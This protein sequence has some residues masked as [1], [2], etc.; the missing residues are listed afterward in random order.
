M[1]TERPISNALA[2]L[3]ERLARARGIGDAY[4]TYK[5]E[6]QRFSLATKAAILGAMHCPLDDARAL[7]REI[8]ESEH[9]HP[10]G[11]LGEVAVSRAGARAVRI[12]TPAIEQN[13]LL[14]WRVSLEDGAERAGEV[15]AW[16]LPERGAWQR[17]GRWYMLRDLPL[18]D[19]PPGYHRLEIDLEMAG[20][21]SCPLIV[22]PERAHQPRELTDGGK[23]WGVAAQIYTL[24][25]EHNW[26]IGDFTDLAELL[27]LAA[28][29]GAGF[30]GVSPLHAL[31]PADPSLYSPYS[32]SSRHALNILFIDVNAVPEVQA[33][34]RAQ[35]LIGT[36]VFKAR[37]AR[38]RAATQVDY[39]GV[40]A[41]KL[42]VLEAAFQL[43]RETHL[44]GDTPRAAQFRGFLGDR[45]EPL[46]LH[47]LFDALDR[48]FRKT[49]GT[50]A[51][52]QNWPREY[53]DP[54]GAA[55][56]RFARERA[57]EVQ[58]FAW[59]QWLAAQQLAAVRQL[60]RELGLAVGLY[61]DYAVGVNASGSETWSD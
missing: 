17:D 35:A 59:L 4:H 26:G 53:R 51:G 23:L 31:F 6:L 27:R 46:Q 33:S 9:V 14:R 11:V 38:V 43:F 24:R 19:L 60:A 34:T 29:A 21:E 25:S 12:N 7:E 57:H 13:A 2:P 58:F 22:A 15:R 5:G 49:L 41:L 20:R 50:H 8:A 61:G 56:Q 1:S 54:R 48:H 42:P 18:P 40:A 30:V 28:G 10:A 47:A 37:L 32:A 39:A 45:G 16:S 3:V 44:A 55:V 36:R 52:W